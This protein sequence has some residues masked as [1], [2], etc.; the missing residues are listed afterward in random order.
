MAVTGTI[1]L[2]VIPVNDQL[3]A[4]NL[5]QTRTYTEGAATVAINDIVVSDVD[6][7]ETV[8]ATLT[9]ADVNA[10]V[11]TT[12]GT[13]T[14]TPATGVWTITNTVASVNAA[15]AAVS[16]TPATNY[17]LDT[18]ISVTIADGGENGTV[19]VTGTITLD[20]TPVND[21]LSATNLTQTRSYTEGAAS[22]AINDI[23]VSD[24]DSGEIVTATLTL[25]DI[26]AGV[27]TTS[28]TATYSSG[29]GVWTITNTVANVNAALA[30]VSFAPATNYDLDT[31]IG[32]TIA[33]GGENGTVA[34]TG[35]ITLD[36]TPVNDQL[37]ATNLTQTRTYTEGAA[38]V[39]INDIV[40]ADADSV[41][42]VTATLTLADINAGVLTTSGTAI[43]IPATGAWTI[44]DTIANVNAALAAVSFTPAT[45]YDLD[46]TVAVTIADGGENGTIA[47]TGTITLDVTPVNDQLSATNLTQTRSYTEGAA[48]VAINDIV[49]SDVDSGET[50]TATLTLADINAG[51]LTTSGTATYTPVT[52]V[53]TITDTLANVNAALAVV[54]FTPVINYSLDTSISVAIADG[55]EN[56]TAIATGTIT[57]DVQLTPVNDQISAT[58]LVQ[59]NTYTEG[60]AAVAINAIVV[61]DVD[62]A[63]AVTATLTLTDINAG[64]LSTS[65]TATYTA[66]TGVWTIT[67]TIANANAALAAVSFTPATNYDLDTTIAVTIADGGEN[68]TVPVTGTITLDVTPVNDQLSAT[69]LT[70]TRPYTEG[71]AAVAI[72]DIVIT[73]VDSGETVTATLT[74]AD[75]NA[76]ALTTSGTATYT[77]ATGVWTITNTVANVNAALA[78]VSFTPTTN[79]DLD[80]T[81]AVTIADGG[82]NGTVAATGTIALDVTPLND[83]LSAT[84]LTQTRTYS[85]G[86]AAVAINDIVITDVDSGE[87]VTATL[88]LAD[89]NAGVLTTS[90]TATYTPGTGLWTIT[91]TITDVNAALAAVSFTPAINYDLNTTIAVTIADGGENGMVAV[92][93]TITLDVMPV[94]DQLSATNLVQARTYTEGGASVVINPIVVSDVDSGETVTATLTLADIN[95]GVLSTSGTATYIPAT[96]VWTITG[97]LANVNAA[98]AA[99]SFVAAT[100]YDLDTSINVTIA[101]GG[102]NGT[103]AVTGIITLDVTP[104]NDQLSATNL[105]QT[106]IYSE[107]AASVAINDIVVSD[108]DSGETVTATLTLA[109]LNAGVLTTSGTATYSPGTGVWTITNTLANVNAALA[110]V[111]FAPAAN[112]DLDTTIAV[113]IADGGENS[114]VAVTGTITLDATPVNDQLSATNLTQTRT[115]SEGAAAVAIND[116]VVSD[117]DSSETVT[118]TLTLA[119]LNA[120]VL[121][122]SGTATYSSGTGVWTI[123]NTVA[124]VNAALAAVSF[125]PTTNYDLDTSISVTIADGGENGTLAVTGI[126]TLDATPVNDQLS[127]TNLFQTRTYTEGAAAVAIDNIVITDVD[128]GETVTATL[129]LADV[130]AGV[131]TTSGTATYTPATG[132]WAISGTLANVNAA[133]AA[134]SF[135]PAI[136]YD[137]DTSIS[138]NIADGGENATL[139]VTGTI[140]LH[141][142]S[143]NDQLTATHLSQSQT[144]TQG[145]A[146]VPL[147]DIVVTDADRGEIVTASLTLA[148]V[149]AGDLTTS[150]GATYSAVTGVWTV[151]DTVANVDAA[152]ATVNFVPALNVG[153]DTQITISIFDGG[154]NGTLAASGTIDLYASTIN[155]PLNATQLTQTVSFVEDAASVALGNI[156]ITDVDSDEIVTATLT[157]ADTKAGTL[158]ASGG[159]NYNANIGV[160]AMNGTLAEVNAALAAVSFTPAADYDQATR[161]AV[162]IADGGENATAAAIGN[163]DLKATPVG[164]TPVAQSITI[165]PH[166]DAGVIVLARNGHDGEEVTHLRISA[167]SN[168]TL[169]LAD[170]VTPVREGEFVTVTQGQDGLRFTLFADSKAQGSFAVAASQDGVTVAAQSGLSTAR[171]TRSPLELPALDQA[172]LARAAVDEFEL[173]RRGTQTSSSATSP[174]HD[175]DPG[176]VRA[177]SAALDTADLSVTNETTNPRQAPVFAAPPTL[178]V[179]NAGA[180]TDQG[181]SVATATEENS[182]GITDDDRPTAKAK[183]GV[184]RVLRVMA[185][186]R[187]LGASMVKAITTD[188]GEGEIDGEVDHA[189]AQAVALTLDNLAYRDQLDGVRKDINALAAMQGTI[190]GSTAIASTGFTIGYVAWLTRGGLLLASMLSSLPA[191]RSVDPL[192]ILASLRQR[193]NHDDEADSLAT[194]LDDQPSHEFDDALAVPSAADVA[195]GDPDSHPPGV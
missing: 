11:L 28:G 59:T 171:I 46:T 41:E 69:N 123:T 94:N 31:T 24:V 97:T 93:G 99:V 125:T 133:L 105:N 81:I 138:V 190:V 30:A 27:L 184:E 108:V 187:A 56:G 158:S 75:I 42:T 152:L 84:N 18:T 147:D 146:A 20:V 100:N 32:V 167:I 54:S 89:I 62:G 141:V 148:D 186:A 15:L 61:S 168:G 26:N 50:V 174:H 1:T 127:A 166:A 65:G 25:A 154:E 13:A 39:A 183:T 189:A 86:A 22:V 43:Y 137:L 176:A 169:T 72:N 165:A 76:G 194:L 130:N 119:D 111:S 17:D 40:I 170:G 136:N 103:V 21:Q 51:M 92:M 139:A 161:I 87:T 12:S 90:G 78:A 104:V 95:A 102:E 44:T 29:T 180:D 4:T 23:V 122:T 195:V 14:Y 149:N 36:V 58:N 83:Q 82:E 110:A 34:V 181:R 5:V 33:D 162:R 63:E 177:A 112:Y 3:S 164:D 118:A 134:A 38:A 150:G 88:T 178:S 163:I 106:R 113:T 67:D 132:V 64:V 10:G 49:V 114:T 66:G 182:A 77:P 129:T 140:S 53:W 70:Q 185:E 6:S 107:G 193:E 71:A 153:H 2:D 9:L 96:G 101:D 74:L 85:E 128:S 126:I 173:A 109:D 188:P 179:V 60:D 79:Y 48:S 142:I 131:L 124:N 155:H 117:V 98:L 8:T 37:S 151:T 144:Y 68:S 157:L 121:T 175:L 57:L 80:T 7:A 115:Y 116:I 73:D 192:P 55:G 19:P 16:F 156:V 47:V 52:G 160:W 135:T 159:A 120:G 143:V 35:T 91:A 45:N 172:L 191:W 145:G